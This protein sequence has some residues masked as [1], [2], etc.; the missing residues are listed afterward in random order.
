MKKINS[1]KKIILFCLF[2]Y[3]LIGFQAASVFAVSVIAK[4]GNLSITNYD[5]VQF[6]AFLCKS[7][8]ANKKENSKDKNQ[9][10]QAICDIKKSLPDYMQFAITLKLKELYI[11]K[12]GIEIDTNSKEFLTYVQQVD[13]EINFSKEKEIDQEFAI[14]ILKN[15]Y[16]WNGLVYH[17]KAQ[18]VE[19]LKKQKKEAQTA[20]LLNDASMQLLAKIK[21]MTVVEILDINE[22]DIFNVK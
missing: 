20:K 4:V 3:Q 8:K 14:D 11:K 13:K 1:A 5:I 15:D 6:G 16:I 19:K 10:K 9:Q 2:F 7:S 12:A 22:Q 17:T 18:D 21:E